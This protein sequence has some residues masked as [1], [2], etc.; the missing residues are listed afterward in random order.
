MK[1][2][3]SPSQPDDDDIAETRY[4][5]EFKEDAESADAVS[6]TARLQSSKKSQS[7]SANDFADEQMI[8]EFKLIRRLGKGGMA[9]VWL[10]EQTS[11][12]RPVALKLL[13]GELLED[14]SY[15]KRFQREATSAAGLAHPNIV[16]VYAVGEE[17]GQHFIAH[18][19]IQ[20]QT[21]RQV[22]TKKGALDLPLALHVIRQVAAA[23]EAAGEKGIIHRDIKPDNIMV[24]KK[25]EVKVADFGLAQ[26]I[27]GGGEALHLT[28]PG[29][30]MGTP[31]YMSPEQVRGDKLDQRSDIYSLGV[32]C[33]HML[34]GRPPF[35]GE[36]AV[37]V[38]MQHLQ[39]EPVPL[40][41]VREDLPRPACDMVH[42]MMA[43]EPVERYAS[44]TDVLND[45][46]TL[47]RAVKAGEADKVQL[48]KLAAPQ[49]DRSIEVRH[50]VLTLSILCLLIA[51]ASAGIGWAM[52]PEIRSTR[53]SR[54][55]C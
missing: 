10:A 12:Q 22:I 3:P 31:L 24:N 4:L 2:N 46:K 1:D 35:Q 50:P 29:E 6:D 20:G 16:A 45:V 43:K 33:Y 9:E 23:L 8:G 37:S 34:A 40:T 32:T 17:K 5:P 38:A 48:S 13:R 51:L 41:S 21:L 54:K 27:Q 25:G 28:Q 53:L 47:L 19:Y 14:E 7:T 49:V 18:E 55:R 15:I 42:R 30:T 36:T 39:S 26:L 11:L 44:A 52:R